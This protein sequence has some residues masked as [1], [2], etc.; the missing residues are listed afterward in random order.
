MLL[1]I[2]KKEMNKKGWDEL[3]F[4]IITGDAYVDHHS[5]GTAIIGRL[6][7]KYGYKVG[8]IPQPDP[9]KIEDFK[10]LGRPRL[11]FLINSG[12]VDSMVNNYSVFK[13]TRKK[14]EYSP[15]G[16]AGL[17]PD[18]AIIVYSNKAR[19]AYKGVPII[20]GG[21]EAS[22][23][24][25]SHYDYWSNKIR[26]SI[27]LDSKADLLIYGMGELTVIE[28]AEALESGI[29]IKDISWIR[30]T[31]ARTKKILNPDTLLLPDY[32]K[33]M[34]SKEEYCKSFVLQY[35]NNDSL[36]AYPLAESYGDFYVVQNIPQLPLEEEELD[37]IY[38]LPFENRWHPKYDKAGGIPAFKEIKHSIVSCRGCFGGCSF[39]AI[40]YHQGRQV[41][42]R[43][44][45]SIVREAEQITHMFDFKGYIN[46]VGGPTAN[47]RK[48]SCKMQLKH[49]MCKR[50]Q[51]LFPKP[52]KH[53]DIDH[54]DYL[55]VLRAVRK[56]EGVKKVFIRSGIRYDYLMAD[57][58]KEFM[59]KLCEYHVS[60]TLKVAPEHVSH[61]VLS[62]MGKPDVE[63][64]DR[65]VE[66]YKKTN[67]KLSKDQYLIPYLIS[68]HPGST[69]EDA[70]TLAIYL[71]NHGFIPDQVQD[72]YPTPGT[73]ATCMY[74]SELDPFTLE[75][76]F[77]AKNMEDKKLQRALIHFNKEE[78]K[79]TVISGLKKAGREDVIEILYGRK[80]SFE[81]SKDHG[82]P[83]KRR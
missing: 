30:G 19:E 77:V 38:E 79:N 80:K 41:R 24:R 83:N 4:I 63:V 29:D 66:E 61:R 28:I 58:Y 44:K 25:F 69:L 9:N 52:C 57:D 78:N 26:K 53:L 36:N 55:E 45:D 1:P 16:E 10:V 37:R 74:Y 33:V 70:I 35:E 49:G 23:R 2:N 73:L 68:S 60:G 17:R 59:E 51:C 13:R 5:F 82:K 48:A 34:V 64:F 71:K 8:I 54:E 7:E 40:T 65:F 14:D 75:P 42:G 27:L 32:E 21:I 62:C 43:S 31:V 47:F 15:G 39:C 56:V 22:L 12:T 50:K 67:K 6:L 20:I 3:D 76:V 46:D 18:R 11:G 81:K 72:F